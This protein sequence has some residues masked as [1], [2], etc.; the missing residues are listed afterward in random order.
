MVI[1]SEPGR[2]PSEGG[3]APA[4]TGQ[5]VKNLGSYSVLDSQGLVFHPSPGNLLFV[6]KEKQQNRKHLYIMV[7]H[8]KGDLQFKKST[9]KIRLIII[10]FEGRR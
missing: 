9:S 3:D 2:L 6:S 10:S 7:F 5:S 8:G 1:G 4:T